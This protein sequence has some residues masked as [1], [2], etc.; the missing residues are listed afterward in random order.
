MY[1]KS[2]SARVSEV[3]GVGGGKVE[4]L[5]GKAEGGLF[6]DARDGEARWALG[7]VDVDCALEVA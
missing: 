2:C 5:V 7:G 3:D 4:D 6:G 1:S